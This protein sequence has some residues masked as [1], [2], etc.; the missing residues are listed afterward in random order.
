MKGSV[1][2][3]G[4]GLVLIAGTGFAAEQVVNIDFEGSAAGGDTTH[5]GD[6]GALS[7]TGGTTW[8]SVPVGT[9][10]MDLLDQFGAGTNVDLFMSVNASAGVDGASTNNLQDSG[11]Q[12]TFYITDLLPNQL[13]TVV[14]YVGV[15]GGFDVRDNTGF[16]GFQGF[17]DPTYALPGVQ[18]G[19]PTDD[20]GDYMRFDNLQ[21]Y[22]IGGGVYALEFSLD[23]LVTGVQIQGVIPTPAT[24]VL[25]GF[26]G[27]PAFAR[28]R[29]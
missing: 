28:R 5:V 2:G 9:T 24:I 29:R 16:V 21:P 10:Q 15:N 4:V 6:D 12:D 7:S 8:N 25:A 20:P 11:V 14:G 26:A 19:G 18:G 22:D 3:F 17:G 27:I 1:I 13:Y 23:G